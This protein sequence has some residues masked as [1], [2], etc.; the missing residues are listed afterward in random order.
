MFYIEGK[1]EF[2]I[3]FITVSARWDS[4]L[5]KYTGY[6][7]CVSPYN[8]WTSRIAN[9]GIVGGIYLDFTRK[10]HKLQEEEKITTDNGNIYF[11]KQSEYPRFKI[12][13]TKYTRVLSPENADYYVYNNDGGNL[14]SSNPEVYVIQTDYCYFVLTDEVFTK[15]GTKNLKT[16]IEDS[17]NHYNY[18]GRRY[19]LPISGKLLYKGKIILSNTKTCSFIKDVMEGKVSKLISDKAFDSYVCKQ[20]NT[21]SIED[22]ETVV[23][24][25]NSYDESTRDLGWKTLQ[26]FNVSE[27]PNV[28]RCLI[29]LYSNKMSGNILKSAGM[30]ATI[31]SLDINERYIRNRSYIYIESLG[32]LMADWK[33][34]D[35]E[36][37][38]IRFVL[39]KSIEKSIS[40][41]LIS[42][43][44][45]YSNLGLKVDYDISF[46]DCEDKEQ[47][48]EETC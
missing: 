16:I 26:G 46:N 8:P 41:K 20:L 6:F 36:R 44:S 18:F 3:L 38:L 37:G 34:N 35:K 2:P 25:L 10:L 12:K 22:L 15:L 31:N 47:S 29:Y 17:N 48:S 7:P 23:E 14:Y 5:N 9:Q 30:Q 21:V 39:K 13:N 33:Y 1:K 19:P 40:D 42:I 24:L 45:T 11:S 32:R 4:N 43:Q 28:F 27:I